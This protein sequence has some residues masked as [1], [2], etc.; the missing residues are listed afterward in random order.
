MSIASYAAL[1]MRAIMRRLGST[2]IDAVLVADDDRQLVDERLPERRQRPFDGEV[3]PRA[4]HVAQS[5]KAERNKSS[6]DGAC[7]KLARAASSAQHSFRT[8]AKRAEPSEDAER[9]SRR[10]DRVGW[11]GNNAM[12]ATRLAKPSLFIFRSILVVALA[13]AMVRIPFHSAAPPEE[14]PAAALETLRAHSSAIARGDVSGIV[15]SGA[16]SP[17]NLLTS[18]LAAA[19]YLRCAPICTLTPKGKARHWIA[20]SLLGELTQ[21]TVPLA[22]LTVEAVTGIDNSIAGRVGVDFSYRVDPNALGRAMLVWA[23]ARRFC[24]IDYAAR[25]KGVQAGAAAFTKDDVRWTLVAAA[26]TRGDSNPFG[27]ACAMP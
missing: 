5:R 22:H 18:Y 21:F 8:C 11:A 1:K 6:P 12:K 24:G 15:F 4:Q 16:A 10:S 17:G 7:G 14:S 3:L 2:S 20:Q 13:G 26:S 9:T 25:W 23:G 27:V 19:H